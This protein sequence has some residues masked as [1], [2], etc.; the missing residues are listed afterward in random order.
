M[1]GLELEYWEPGQPFPVWEPGELIFRGGLVV[2]IDVVSTYP[3]RRLSTAELI[4][5]LTRLRD[6]V[7]SEHPESSGN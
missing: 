5:R 7:S 3:A 2:G 4:G 1:D 6:E